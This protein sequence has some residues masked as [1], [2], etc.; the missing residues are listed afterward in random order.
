MVTKHF[1]KTLA[2]FATM[3][4]VGM[5]GVY[6]VNTYEQD[7]EVQADIATDCTSEDC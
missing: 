2:L 3:I 1:L 7:K 4:A 5:I 6:L